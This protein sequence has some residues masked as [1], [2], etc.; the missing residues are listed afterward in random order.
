MVC[1]LIGGSTLA[2]RWGSETPFVH[3]Q[4]KKPYASPQAIELN[5]RCSEQAHFKGPRTGFE[6]ENM[7]YGCAFGIL[8]APSIIRPQSPRM[9]SVGKSFDSFRAAGTNGRLD[10]SLSWGISGDPA[11][12]PGKIWSRVPHFAK[13][14]VAPKR[15]SSS[16]WMLEGIS[17][18]SVSV[19]RRH[20]VTMRKAS[21]KT[22]LMRRVC[23]LRH[24]TGAQYLAVD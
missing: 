22:L 10:F 21:F 19:G 20:P 15:Q 24:Q 4:M 1:G 16:G 18:W 23:A 11:S 5:L 2:I 13:E 3:G 17:R 7:E 12:G 9:P 6:N 8:C 14:S